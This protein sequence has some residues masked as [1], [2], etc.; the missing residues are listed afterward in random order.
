MGAA[1]CGQH[2]RKQAKEILDGTTFLSLPPPRG[3][4][5]PQASE[6]SQP[7][8]LRRVS[9]PPPRPAPLSLLPVLPEFPG[10]QR[11]PPAGH[12]C[13]LRVSP[14]LALL[15]VAPT[16]CQVRLKSTCVC[17]SFCYDAATGLHCGLQR[18]QQRRPVEGLWKACGLPAHKA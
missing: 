16:G 7:P 12:S 2:N 18:L 9:L 5:S 15:R 8:A 10:S 11:L 1:S 3:S 4:C 17:E 13:L 14:I 6:A